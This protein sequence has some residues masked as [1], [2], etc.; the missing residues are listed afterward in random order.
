MKAKQIE[1]L[2]QAGK[3]LGDAG[4]FEKPFFLRWTI[5]D[6]KD[7]VGYVNAGG[8]PIEAANILVQL[9][10]IGRQ[11]TAAIDA[12]LATKKNRRTDSIVSE[13]PLPFEEN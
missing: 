6:G 8:S 11:E 13:F 3:I 5:K 4:A 2:L 1:Q 7:F 10:E 9:L 12:Y